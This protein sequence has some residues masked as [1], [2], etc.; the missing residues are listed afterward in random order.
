MQ[1]QEKTQ[2]L[3]QEQEQEQTQEQSKRK[4]EHAPAKANEAIH[5]ISSTQKCHKR[6]VV[7]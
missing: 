3:E 2:E 7:K 1:A 5:A 4:R 6:Q